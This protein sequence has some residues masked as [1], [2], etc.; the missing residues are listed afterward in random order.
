MLD[1]NTF[2]HLLNYS[3]IYA[4]LVSR[5]KREN[6][7]DLTL[8]FFNVKFHGRL[9]RTPGPDSIQPKR[10]SSFIYIIYI[11]SFQRLIYFMIFISISIMNLLFWQ[12]AL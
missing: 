4:V 10:S 6:M 12:L 5:Y 11:Y 8:P 1:C 9:Y 2:C 3:M 7:T